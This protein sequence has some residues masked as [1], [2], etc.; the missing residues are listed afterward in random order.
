MHGGDHIAQVLQAQGVPFLFT[1]CGGHISPILTACKARGIRV[2]DTRHEATAVFA[3]DAV[4]RLSGRP[5]VAAVTAGPGLTNTI[6]AIKNAQVAQSPLVLLG[7]ATATALKGRG[8]LQDIDQLALIRPHVK[9]AGAARRVADL[10]PMLQRA[11]RIAQSG[12]PGP[13]FL[14][15]PVDLLYPRETVREWYLAAGGGKSLAARVTGA[16]LRLHLARLFRGAQTPVIGP[17][18]GAPP[19]EPAPQLVARAA[20]HLAR[21]RR[22]LL[23]IGAQAMLDAQAAEALAQAVERLGVPV[24]LSGAAR[25]LLGRSHPLLLRH[26]RRAALKAADLVL[27]AGVPCDFRLDYGRHIRRGATYIAV[28]RSHHDLTLNR[29]PTLGVLGDPGRFLIRLAEQPRA[30]APWGDWLSQRRADDHERELTIDHQAREPAAGLNPIHVCRSIEAALPDNSL[31][32]GDGGDFVATAAYTISPRGPLRWLDPGPFGTLGVG[33]GF[34]IG[35]ALCRPD[36]EIWALFGDGAFGYSLAEIDTFV[37]HGLPVISVVGNDAGW[38]QIARDQVAILGDPVGTTLTANHYHRLAESL[39]AAGLLA[40]D[41]ELLADLLA[42]ARGHAQSGRPVVIN[43][44]LGPSDFR[45]GS[46]SI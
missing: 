31:L 33:A 46:L 32:I 24:Y 8:A 3:A 25:G 17:P 22:P 2:I 30:A 35:A 29:R 23:I 14:E 27:L 21:A 18:I 11:F 12:V 5:G 9:W 40:E 44:L 26:Q 19:P 38:T 41:P 6:T 7:G 37:R 28:N 16:Y 34:A 20:A 1:L 36:C 4:A 43:A 13:V 39:G 45:K 10:V 15:C 42:E